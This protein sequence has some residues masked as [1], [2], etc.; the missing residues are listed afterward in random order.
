MT[1]ICHLMNSLDLEDTPH[2]LQRE[3]DDI[4]PADHKVDPT[5]GYR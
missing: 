3:A 4:I 5:A 1:I 2:Y